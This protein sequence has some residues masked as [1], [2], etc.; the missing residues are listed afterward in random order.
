M[1]EIE[2]RNNFGPGDPLQFMI[3]D[4]RIIDLQLQH[5]FDIQGNQLDRARHPR[6][7]VFVPYDQPVLEN[8]ILRRVGERT[9]E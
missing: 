4:G 9:E 7:K 1:V 3:P 2:Q 6:Q 5:L 8:S